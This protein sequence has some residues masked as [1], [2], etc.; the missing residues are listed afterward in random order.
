MR[1]YSPFFATLHDE[2][3]PVGNL[4]R[5]THYSVLRAVIHGKDPHFHD[6]AVIWDE[7]HDARIIW[8]A[9]KMY[10]A[11]L[12]EAA[13]FIGERKGNIY[14]VTATRQPSAYERAVSDIAELV[15][16][17]SFCAYVEPMSDADGIIS[18]KS[19]VV[20]AYLRGIDALWR[21]GPKPL[22]FSVQPFRAP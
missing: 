19:D 4:G 13:L 6:F 15:P 5:G 11:G 14:V 16:S 10:M 8:I 1:T 22:E 21:F 7:D 20:R 18:E 12:L 2:Q 9:E 17:D 3:A